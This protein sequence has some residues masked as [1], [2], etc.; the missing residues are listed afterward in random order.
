[1]H[2]RQFESNSVQRVAIGSD[3]IFTINYDKLDQI[4]N[5]HRA[6]QLQPHTYRRGEGRSAS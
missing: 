3:E 2:D 5:A 4:F 1:M 6:R